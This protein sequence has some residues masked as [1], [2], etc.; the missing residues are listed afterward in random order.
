MKIGIRR[1]RG[2]RLSAVK[3]NGMESLRE[4]YKVGSGPSSSHTMGPEKAARIFKECYPMADR[5]RVVLYGSLAKTGKGH[6]TDMV[7]KKTLAPFPCE[8]IF[9]LDKEE[10]ELAHPNTMELFAYKKN[11]LVGQDRVCSVG[12]GKIRFEGASATTPKRIYPHSTFEEIAAYCREKELYLWQYVE[13][14]EG[15]NFWEYM[16]DIWEAMKA[17]I[18]RGLNDEGILPGGLNVQK[19]ARYLYSLEHIDESAETR[20]NRIV[21]S[22]AFA[23]SEQNACGGDACHQRCE[24]IQLFK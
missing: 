1:E 10:R 16:A 13:E 5:F 20:E 2:I 14:A 9:D 24:F 7:I 17:S 21:S 12:G 15:A 11:C 23:V 22:Y 19:K 6:C 3:K 8:I 18:R 4:L